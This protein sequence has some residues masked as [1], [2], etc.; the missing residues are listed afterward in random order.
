LILKLFIKFKFKPNKQT[1]RRRRGESLLGKPGGT[2]FAKMVA[3][4]LGSVFIPLRRRQ[5]RDSGDFSRD[6]ELSKD[7][8]EKSGVFGIH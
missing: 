2:G 6:S 4:V 5:S 8:G 7:S 1:R 3:L